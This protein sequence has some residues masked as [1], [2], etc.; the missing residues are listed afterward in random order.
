MASVNERRIIGL[1]DAVGAVGGGIDGLIEWSLSFTL[2]AWRHPGAEVVEQSRRCELPAPRDRLPD[3]VALVR[4]HSIIEGELDEGSTLQGFRLSRI[5]D[6]N[7]IDP[8]LERI[9][10]E[11]PPPIVAQAPPVVLQDPRLGRLEYDPED[12]SFQGRADWCGR[13]VEIRLACT[14]EDD[15]ATALETAR[16]LFDEQEFWH[17]RVGEYAVER[18]LPLKNESWLE[19][20]ESELDASGFLSRMTLESISVYQSG[21][22]EFW[23]HDGDLFWGHAIQI[24]GLLE[25]LR[26]A[27]IPG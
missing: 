18:L 19:E 3:L 16:R 13:D 25:G 15:R 9:A 26:L 2:S 27:D 5:V 14:D 21:D 17:R 12:E 11:D 7:A 1:V 10:R 24:G 23:F 6:F 4:P 22:F 20:G 8:D